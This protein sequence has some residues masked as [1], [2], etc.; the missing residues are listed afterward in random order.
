MSKLEKIISENKDAFDALEPKGGHFER[1]QSKL[2]NYHGKSRKISFSFVLKVAAVAVLVVLSSLW[3]YDTFISDQAGTTSSDGM[4]AT[5]ISPEYREAEAYYAS[6]VS[7]KYN[8]FDRLNLND[9]IEKNMIL[10]ELSDM[11]S[12]YNDLQVELQANPNDERVINAMISYYQ[13]KIE[14]LNKIINRLNAIKPIKTK[15]NESTEV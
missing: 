13:L 10:N 4:A 15:Q 11:D 14:V 3:T 6:L 12:L 8:E 2:D 5:D 7:Q 1:F 9:S